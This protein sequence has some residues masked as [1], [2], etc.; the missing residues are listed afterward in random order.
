MSATLV[1]DAA[2][3]SRTPESVALMAALLAAAAL[4]RWLWW[5]ARGRGRDGLFTWFVG[6][7]L[8]MG[9]V[10]V[11]TEIERRMIAVADDVLV[12]EGAVH[13]V[14]DWRRQRRAGKHDYEKWQ[15]FWIRDVGFS[16][17]LNVDMNYFHNAEPEKLGLRDGLQLRVHYREQRDGDAVSRHIVR[18]ERLDPPGHPS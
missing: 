6:A 13:G 18:V 7:A 15:G 11:A 2:T 3:M 8:L 12:V 14:V 10:A 4:G 9:G 16:Y 17:A 5:R 1:Y